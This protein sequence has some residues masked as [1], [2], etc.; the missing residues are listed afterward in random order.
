MDRAFARLVSQMGVS[1]VDAVTVCATTPARALNLQ[2]FGV[3][4]AGAT[5]DLVVLDARLN[6]VH[7]FM[8]GSLVWSSGTAEKGA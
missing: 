4:A 5:A 7:T 8:D 6:V 2:G 3:I 1:L